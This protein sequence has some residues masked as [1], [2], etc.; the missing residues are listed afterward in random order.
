MRKRLARADAG[1]ALPQP[2]E[3]LKKR[4]SSATPCL[5][6]TPPKMVAWTFRHIPNTM[7]KKSY[8]PQEHYLRSPTSR[9]PKP[10]HVSI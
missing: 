1:T 6:S 4:K 8:F 2:A 5:L 9:K 7:K 10:K 3:T